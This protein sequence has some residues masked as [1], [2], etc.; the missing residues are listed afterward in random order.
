MEAQM[1]IP[2]GSPL[3]EYITAIWEVYGNRNLSETILPKGIFEMVFNLA[4]E[5]DGILPYGS[6]SIRTPKCFIQGIHTQVINANYHGQQHL[7]GIR[8]QPHMIGQ[9]LGLMPSELNNIIVDLTLIKPEFGI[10]WEQ[11]MEVASFEERVRI[12]EKAF[13][14]LSDTDS[15]QTKKL[16]HLFLA[17]SIESFQ[18]VEQL[19]EQVYYSSRHLN[20]KVHH[21]FGMSAEELIMYKKFL[22]SVNLMHSQKTTLTDIAYQSG[23]YDQSHF[24]RIF[25]KYTG[26]TAKEYQTQKGAL[27]FHLF[28]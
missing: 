15:P 23:F 19:T 10:L 16:S 22:H 4:D 1:H 12:I 26:I 17:D 7:F 27:P 24:S 8:V 21:I 20:R 11:L 2:T 5:M 28:S 9:L 3:K 18:S 6:Q 25:K 14:V 13:P